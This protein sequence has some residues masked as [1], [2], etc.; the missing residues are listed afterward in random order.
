M[1]FLKVYST[2][3]LFDA[4]AMPKAAPCQNDVEKLLLFHK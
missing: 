1:L 2:L 3:L 4:K